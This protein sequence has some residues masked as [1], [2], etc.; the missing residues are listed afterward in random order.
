MDNLTQAGLAIATA[1]VGL[2]I[3]A[4]LV[5]KQAQTPAVLGAAGQSLGYVIAQAVSPV[6]SG[7]GTSTVGNLLTNSLGNWVGGNN[8]T[9]LGTGGLY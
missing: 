1:I 8:A 4:V 3:V 7:A 2:A 5:S 6:T 9:M